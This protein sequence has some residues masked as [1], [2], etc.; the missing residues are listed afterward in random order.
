[1][2]IMIL[3]LGV[4]LATVGLAETASAHPPGSG[5]GYGGGYGRGYSGGYGGGY[6]AYRGG[7]FNR[8]YSG[9]NPGYSGYRPSYGYSPYQGYGYSSYGYPQ[10][11]Y[12]PGITFGFNIP[13]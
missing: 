7:T 10:Y 1:M 5:G 12:Q 2:K 9:Y 4:G 13:R 3:A 6:G 8:G 11:G